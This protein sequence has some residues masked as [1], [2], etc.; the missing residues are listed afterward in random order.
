MS[1]K[2]SGKLIRMESFQP[3]Q[4]FLEIKKGYVMQGFF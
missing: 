4:K 2:V 1:D 3:D